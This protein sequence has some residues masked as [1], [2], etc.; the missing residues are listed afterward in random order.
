LAEQE[1]IET[2]LPPLDPTEGATDEAP[3]GYKKDGTPAKKRGRQAGSGGGT[4]TG[5]GKVNVTQE[6]LA[7]KIV[8][9]LAIPLGYGSPLALAVV[10]DRAEKFAASLLVLAKQSPRIAK[11][12]NSFVKT[13][14]YGELVIFPIAVGLAVMVDYGQLPPDM[15]VARKLGITDKY[16]LLHQDDW[17][18][19]GES[20]SNGNGTG[21]H[22]GLV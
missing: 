14:A 6:V 22:S 8:E 2:E 21:P 12:V 16:I 17:K 10:D 4:S 18:S 15:I 19:Q 7:D 13:S 20:E 5:S 3:Y 1:L 9:L 11:A